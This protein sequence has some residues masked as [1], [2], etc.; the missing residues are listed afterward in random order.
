VT[1]GSSFGA[2]F[3]INPQVDDI[4][5]KY[6]VKVTDKIRLL[7]LGS[8]EAGGTGCFCPEHA[9]LRRL[10]KHLVLDRND[11]LIMDM[12]AG[13]EHLGRGTAEGV[14]LMLIVVE[15]GL[16]SVEAARRIKTLAAD[17]GIRKVAAVVN[18]V[19]ES[20]DLEAISVEM[21]GL[22]TP[23]LS[24]ISQDPGLVAA[25]LEGESPLEI[26]SEET[27]CSLERLAEGM[28]EFAK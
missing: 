27:L 24:S 3:K 2:I 1:P 16:R 5:D 14:D 8:V 6:G 19:R 15:P 22:G 7:V 18:K 23:I 11:V 12:E 20:S 21:Q 10:T 25:D 28:S 17:V 13:V 26:A 9:L 4:V